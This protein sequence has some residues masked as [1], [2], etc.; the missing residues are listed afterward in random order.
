[1]PRS[2]S[3]DQRGFTL[4]EL[5]IVVVIIAI[6]AAIAIPKFNQVSRAAKESE[7]P[8][9]LKEI[10]TLEE[11]YF[12]MNDA[13]APAIGDLEGGAG[14]GDPSVYY[15]FSVVMVAGEACAVATPTA[16]G[17]DAGLAAQ[18]MNMNRTLFQS[19][20]CS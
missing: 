11:R 16:Q 12:Q 2:G 9:I 4:I 13:Y 14:I 1:M 8:P 10:V 3:R 19:A 7:A 18:S 20:N 15:D 5:M 6:L 17:A